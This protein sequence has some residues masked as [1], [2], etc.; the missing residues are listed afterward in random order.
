MLFEYYSLFSF[1]ECLV[2]TFCPPM[3]HCQ[4]HPS[5]ARWVAFAVVAIPIRDGH[6]MSSQAVKSYAV[7]FGGTSQCSMLYVPR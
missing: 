6:L 5:T 2:D 1:G 7:I 3:T 4:M